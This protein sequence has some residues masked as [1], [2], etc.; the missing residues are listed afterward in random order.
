LRARRILVATA[1]AAFVSVSDGSSDT[2]TAA[3]TST[4]GARASAA[5]KIGPSLVRISVSTGRGVRTGSGLVVRADGYL[6]T[7]AALVSGLNHA[8][9]LCV[10]LADGR[11]PIA[12]LVGIDELVGLAVLRVAGVG[13][14]V[15]ATFADTAKSTSE[16]RP[17]AARSG[18]AQLDH[19][20]KVAGVYA[21]P[22]GGSAIPAE[23]AI[24]TAV[25][26]I[27]ARR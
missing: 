14:L 26:L 4:A 7:G 12:H 6:L 19:A 8:A 13:D 10:T 1:I 11:Q 17:V 25:E 3:P 2:A 21:T 23:Q 24:R 9:A 15:P 22:S 16:P 5:A 27:A 20:G 18:M